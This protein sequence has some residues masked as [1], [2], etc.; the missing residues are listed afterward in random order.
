MIPAQVFYPSYF[1]FL[2]RF[3]SSLYDSDDPEASNGE[4]EPTFDGNSD[5]GDFEWS[6]RDYLSNV[7]DNSNPILGR[8]Y[9]LY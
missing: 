6:L 9:D 8:K 4:D 2:D 3:M 1:R 7:S 5:W